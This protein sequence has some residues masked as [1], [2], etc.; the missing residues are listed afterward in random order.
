MLVLGDSKSRVDIAQILVGDR[1]VRGG[2]DRELELLARQ[3]LVAL[4]SIEHGQ[5]IARL[6]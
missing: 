2:R 4:R 5:V 6:G 1:V 3:R